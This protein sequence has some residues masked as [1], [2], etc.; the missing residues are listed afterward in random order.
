M[1]AIKAIHDWTGAPGTLVSWSPSATSLAKMAAAPIS[2]V[3]VSY[4]QEQ[5]IRGYR[6]HLSQ[7]T[8]M[9]R[10][11]IPAWDMPGATFGR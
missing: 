5:H 9:A 6:K 2:P 10:L 7:G 8:D 1:V 11:N 4:Q 3:P